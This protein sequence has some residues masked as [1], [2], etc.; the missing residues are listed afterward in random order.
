MVYKTYWKRIILSGL[1][2]LLSSSF[3]YF[4]NKHHHRDRNI[5]KNTS[6]N[7]SSSLFS[8][9]NTENRNIFSEINVLKETILRNNF[10]L[11]SYKKIIN[12]NINYQKN[13]LYKRV[14]FANL[15]IDNEIKILSNMK[16]IINIHPFN[17]LEKFRENNYYMPDISPITNQNKFTST[18]NIKTFN[19]KIKS[20]KPYLNSILDNSQEVF[21]GIKSVGTLISDSRLLIFSKDNF[22]NS[23]IYYFSKNLNILTTYNKYLNTKNYYDKNL[24]LSENK[25]INKFKPKSKNIYMYSKSDLSNKNKNQSSRIN[26]KVY[27]SFSALLLVAGIIIV[28]LG[29]DKVFNKRKGY[30]PRRRLN[31]YSDQKGEVK[32]RD[33]I[34]SEHNPVSIELKH[35]QS[36]IKNKDYDSENSINDTDYALD[37]P[38]DIFYL[39]SN[40]VPNNESTDR[41]LTLTGESME[42]SLEN[43]ENSTQET[44]NDTTVARVD[45]LSNSSKAVAYQPVLFSNYKPKQSHSHPIWHNNYI[46]EDKILDSL[47]KDFEEKIFDNEKKITLINSWLKF[48]DY[49]KSVF[50]RSLFKSASK[51]RHVTKTNFSK[52]V[53]SFLHKTKLCSLQEWSR[54]NSLQI[55][56]GVRK[57]VKKSN[58]QTLSELDKNEAI[59]TISHVTLFQWR[60]EVAS[61]HT[62]LTNY[63]WFKRPRNEMIKILSSENI[64]RDE[65]EYIK[66]INRKFDNMDLIL[67]SGMNSNYCFTT[68]LDQIDRRT[69]TPGVSSEM[70]QL[71]KYIENEIIIDLRE[72]IRR[73]KSYIVISH[74]DAELLKDHIPERIEF[75]SYMERF[76]K[77]KIVKTVYDGPRVF[78]TTENKIFEIINDFV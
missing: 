39:H 55:F 45:A 42:A 67:S 35:L 74:I 3:M 36:H 32:I 10:I 76:K 25:F 4:F 62:Y 17:Y 15:S 63:G 52:Q 64:T 47:V 16:N 23:N 51:T 61:K 27:I 78:G 22:I 2:V 58:V 21:V 66:E 49:Q 1:I 54:P 37:D 69:I 6:N 70:T 50:Y 46:Y 75:P 24:L 13:I 33:S 7:I 77:S 11:N 26:K 18:T 5:I 29:K 71:D 8:N 40:I 59:A 12:H 41:G 38:A 48:S 20:T 43:Q 60:E 44:E 57:R 56:S 28:I 65:Y 72:L 68:L 53:D 19:I 14:K 30:N 9:H 31:I 73:Y 34:Q